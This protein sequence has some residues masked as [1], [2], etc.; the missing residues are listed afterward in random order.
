MTTASP[1][2]SKLL[3]GN[4]PRAKADGVAAVAVKVRLLDSVNKPVANTQVELVADREGVEIEQPGLTDA[5]GY[6]LGLVRAS[7]P[8]P[9]T[10]SCSV[11]P[12]E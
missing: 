8:G 3:H 9:V 2:N 4:R 7:T 12:P 5:E 1:T 10:I 11:L 6:A